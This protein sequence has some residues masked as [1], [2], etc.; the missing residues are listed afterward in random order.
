MRHHRSFCFDDAY[1]PRRTYPGVLYGRQL[2]GHPIHKSGIHHVDF[3]RKREGPHSGPSFHITLRMECVDRRYIHV[4]IDARTGFNVIFYIGVSHRMQVE[5]YSN[6]DVIIHTI[7]II[8]FLTCSYSSSVISPEAKRL[9]RISREGSCESAM[10]FFCTPVKRVTPHTKRKITR[11]QNRTRK[12]IPKAPNPHIPPIIPPGK[13]EKHEKSAGIA[14]KTDNAVLTRMLNI[15]KLLSFLSYINCNSERIKNQEYFIFLLI[16]YTICN[17][18]A[19]LSL[20]YIS[21]ILQIY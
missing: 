15:I 19:L 2:A 21:T 12:T 4:S 8:F 20:C 14:D 3:H 1:T 13:P 9:F 7:Y 6:Q 17:S 16:S 10:G 18:G 11:P 5:V